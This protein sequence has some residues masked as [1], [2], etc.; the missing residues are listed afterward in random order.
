MPAAVTGCTLSGRFDVV[1]TM[2]SASFRPC[3][4]SHRRL[5]VLATAAG[6][7]CGLIMPNCNRR[8]TGTA[9]VAVVTEKK[10]AHPCAEGD[11]PELGGNSIH[12]A[13]RSCQSRPGCAPAVTAVIRARFTIATGAMTST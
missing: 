6:E 2:P 1:S 3:G 11:R 12:G 13:L 4:P 5:G 8:K 9:S 10:G 7:K